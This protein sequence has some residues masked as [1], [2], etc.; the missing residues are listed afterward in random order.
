MTL[1]IDS[2]N[3][4][5]EVADAVIEALD[6]RSVVVFR[7]EMGAGKTTLIREI[8]A[9]LGSEDNVTSPTFAIVNQYTTADCRPVYHFDFYRIDRI[10]EAYDFGYEEYFYS[11]DLCLVEWPE[12]IE[13]LLPDDVMTVRI[14]ADTE[15]ERTFRID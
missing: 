6:G 3:E 11:G 13:E 9:R 8:L 10:E 14:T 1:H 2:L 7:G 5:P 4:L 15:E 12:K